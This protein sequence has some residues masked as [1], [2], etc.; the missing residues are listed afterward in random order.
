MCPARPYAEPRTRCRHTQT[1][2]SPSVKTVTFS[3]QSSGWLEFHADAAGRVPTIHVAEQRVLVDQ[4]VVGN[5]VIAPCATV[6]AA[7]V[8]HEAPVVP[9]EPDT[10]R[11]LEHV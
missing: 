3:R 6:R 5:Q 2:M 4:V 8:E 1:T 7:H 9:G 10:K 11:H